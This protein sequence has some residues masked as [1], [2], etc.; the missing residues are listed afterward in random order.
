[1]AE[2]NLP[3]LA[4][5]NDIAEFHELKKYFDAKAEED[6]QALARKSF[7]NPEGHDVLEWERLRSFYAGVDAVLGLP[8]IAK[9][10]TSD[11]KESP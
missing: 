1:M 6:V 9:Q 11:R 8:K 3:M 7:K 4:R 10:R 5:L 2:A